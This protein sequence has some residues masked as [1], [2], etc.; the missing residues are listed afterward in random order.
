MN[1]LTSRTGR[2]P[3]RE[4]DKETFWR[5]TLKEQADSGQNVRAFCRARGLTEPSFYAWRRTI[6]ERDGNN[7]SRNAR[8]KRP[9]FVELRPQ[10]AAPRN[11]DV[12]LEIVAGDRRLL[13]RPGCDRT[14][15]REVLAVLTST[16]TAESGE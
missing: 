8:T 10:S 7:A 4:S 3:H 16:S 5:R 6:A 15:L 11:A 13:I 12:P 1:N 14:L 2:G 9:T